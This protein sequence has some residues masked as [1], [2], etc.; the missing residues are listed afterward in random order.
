MSLL[1]YALPI[2]AAF[3][4]IVFFTGLPALHRCALPRAEDRRFT[5]ADALLLALLVL[6]YGAVAFYR[7][8][9]TASPE[10]FVPMEGQS[11]TLTL[12]EDGE[13]AA[14]WLFTGVG[15]GN[16]E[17]ECSADGESFTPLQSYE[18]N[19]AS[20]LKWDSVSLADAPRPLRCLRLTCASGNPWLGELAVC[21]ADGALLPLSADVPALC[22]EGDTVPEKS[23]FMNSSYFDEIYHARTAWEHLNGVWP[24][25]I[26]HPP[27]GK[28]ILS[29]GVLLFG[30]TPF[31]W[32]FSGTLF[33]VLML[34]AM[35][36]LLKRLFGG[37]EVPTLGTIVFA[38]DFMHF[39]QTRIATIDTYTVFFI[40]L[41][42]LLMYVWLE[43][44]KPWA[45]AL[46]GLSFGLGAASKWTG[47]Y[48]GAGLAVLWLLHW[49][50]TFFVRRG[51]PSPEGDRVSGGEPLPPL[52]GEGD[53]VS[54]GGV[55]PA[56]L[57]NV[58]L[59][60]VFFVALPALIY[61][62]SYIPYG[63]AAGSAPFSA[64]YTRTVLDNQRFMFS[65]HAGIVAEHPYSSRWYQWLLNIRPILYYLEYFPDG[66]HSSI[67]A[68]LNPA[69]CWGGFLSLFV[70]GY[71]ALFRADRRA[72]FI[73]I[74]Y[75]AQ[76]LPWVF[77]AR[78]T[79]AY[80]YFPSS[81]FLVLALGY[82]FALLREN[83]PR[84]RLY[85]VPFALASLLLFI[86]FYPALSGRPY[87]AP[88]TALAQGLLQWLPTWPI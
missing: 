67:C 80:H 45:L 30:M 28:E 87:G 50:E 74:G 34:P 52:K 85:A 3:L 81:V 5:G 56:F 49:L 15:S 21:A 6:V 86:L 27:L 73:L 68:F 69:L 14:L 39:V 9:N 70:L 41:S 84:W 23:D 61:Y 1:P 57:K 77:I 71:E 8:G 64:A 55:F 66:S 60:L 32:R 2:A 25:E 29:L 26:S 33:G 16:Y 78:L 63:R 22:D 36:C 83:R 53:R 79:F 35:Y 20:V 44:E 62:L 58:L 19:Y 65:Y 54:G 48:A 31:G 10:S 17:I 24:Y 88:G 59:C 37:K 38:T 82:V 75:L 46:C 47:L 40:L 18:Q 13:P 12:P 7:L 76:L 43:D 11:V 4:L 72:G 51:A 42:Y